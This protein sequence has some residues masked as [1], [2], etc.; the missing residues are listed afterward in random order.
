MKSRNSAPNSHATPGSPN[1]SSIRAASISVDHCVGSQGSVANDDS[2][3]GCASDQPPHSSCPI[4]RWNQ[5]SLLRSGEAA[6]TVTTTISSSI[7]SAT[8]SRGTRLLRP[9]PGAAAVPAAAREVA[10]ARG[11]DGRGAVTVTP[12]VSADGG[13][14]GRKPPHRARSREVGPSIGRTG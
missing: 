1:Q 2:A 9:A 7:V 13:L 10:S 14:P 11:R 6:C 12:R 4:R 5:V 3:P 8:V